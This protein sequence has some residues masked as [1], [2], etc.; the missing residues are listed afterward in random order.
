LLAGVTLPKGGGAIHGMGEK[1]LV[2]AATG[3]GNLSIPLP[4]GTGRFT[5]QW[6][7][8]YDSGSANGPFGFGWSL[9]LPA[10]TRKTDNGL[11]RYCDGDES[12]VFIL[13][14]AEDLVPVLDGT[15][16]RKQLARKLHGTSYR[17]FF[18]R[19]RIEGLFSR[20]ERWVAQDHWRTIGRD[21]VTVLV[22]IGGEASGDRAHSSC[23]LRKSCTDPLAPDWFE[24]DELSASCN[25]G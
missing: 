3:T 16:A 7:L 2:N 1:F 25:C 18:Y 13:A 10:I 5:P 17:I 6:Q 19:P 21:N 23:L 9:G 22:R 8:A 11:P 15:G 12:D 24:G 4:F 20:I 14:G